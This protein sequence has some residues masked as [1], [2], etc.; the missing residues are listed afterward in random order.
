MAR[1]NVLTRKMGGMKMKT[2]KSCFVILY[3][4]VLSS[5]LL[6]CAQI[7]LKKKTYYNDLVLTL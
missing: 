7:H 6:F 4:P 1:K 5:Y 2:K 3:F